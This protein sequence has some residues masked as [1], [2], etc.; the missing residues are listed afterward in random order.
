LYQERK[1][2]Q[3]LEIIDP[4][5]PAALETLKDT[6]VDVRAILDNNT[7]VLIEMQ[8]LRMK[9]FKK[10]VVYNLAKTYVNQ[11]KTGEIYSKLAPVIAITIAD[12]NLFP[13]I[14][15]IITFWEFKEV[16]HGI[17]YDK[18]MQMVFIE[19][20]K[21]NKKLEEL[22]T[23]TDKWLYVFTESENLKNIPEKIEQI[24][25]MQQALTIANRVGLSVEELDQLQ[26]REMFL[27]DQKGYINFAK[28]EAREQGKQTERLEFVLLLLEERFG[29]IPEE[30][31]IEIQQL[32]MSALQ[33][34][35]IA[36][37]KFNNIEQVM[38]FIRSS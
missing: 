29:E 4:Y 15:E 20:P 14:E 25:E 12:F 33:N 38:E 19:L 2:I 34:L 1:V 9:A 10:R 11:L 26:K 16:K 31:K 13:V 36:S 6:Y 3:D 5:N 28:E 23:I 27:A 35:G 18:E 30:V 21:F 8:L 32:S 17:T 7:T 22:E 24:P 37:L